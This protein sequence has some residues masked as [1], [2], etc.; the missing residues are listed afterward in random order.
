M[1][2]AI[3][4]EQIY[5]DAEFGK[6]DTY[7]ALTKSWCDV[8]PIPTE[9]ELS[10]AW[11]TVLFAREEQAARDVVLASQIL[12]MRDKVAMSELTIEGQLSILIDVVNSLLPDEPK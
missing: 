6:A 12:F 1:D 11:D 9:W 8:R 5:P 2:I 7:Q 10:L 4:V 3:A